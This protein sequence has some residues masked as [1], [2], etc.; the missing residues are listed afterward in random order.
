MG[1]TNNW[2]EMEATQDQF[3]IHF[4]DPHKNQDANNSNATDGVLAD[5]WVAL[6]NNWMTPKTQ[7]HDHSHGNY[8][9]IYLRKHLIMLCSC[10]YYFF[11]GFK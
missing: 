1:T 6:V 5:Q 8:L 4:F 3:E 7:V 10:F 11:V 9:Q 2:R